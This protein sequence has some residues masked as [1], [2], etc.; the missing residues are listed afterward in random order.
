MFPSHPLQFT[1]IPLAQL[2]KTRRQPGGGP[3]DVCSEQGMALIKTSARVSHG[4]SP[5]K[6]STS[7]MVSESLTV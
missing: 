6:T 7:S 4:Y 2:H 5:V 3:F 1:P